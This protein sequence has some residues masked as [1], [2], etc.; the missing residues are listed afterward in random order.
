MAPPLAA[1]PSAVPMRGS[2]LPGQRELAP[3]KPPPPPH[4]SPGARAPKPPPAKMARRDAGADDLPA[5]K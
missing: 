3:K 5:S 1:K 4:Q 2:S